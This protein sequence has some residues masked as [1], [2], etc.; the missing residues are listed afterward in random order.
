MFFYHCGQI[1]LSWRHLLYD[2]LPWCPTW[3]TFSNG[4]HRLRF[5]QAAYQLAVL[6]AWLWHQSKGSTPHKYKSDLSNRYLRDSRVHCTLGTTV[7]LGK[8]IKASALSQHISE[9]F[10]ATSS[11]FYE[12]RPPLFPTLSFSID[13]ILKFKI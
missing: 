5:P 9:R 10:V 13:L 8:E 12:I 11:M 3:P 2:E 4:P 6:C 1:Y 7:S